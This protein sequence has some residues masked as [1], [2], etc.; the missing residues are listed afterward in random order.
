MS[1]SDRQLARRSL[2]GDRTAFDRL[3]HRH[4]PRV[5]HFLRRLTGDDVV[6]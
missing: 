2:S 1:G 4:A 5:F 6:S 3:Y